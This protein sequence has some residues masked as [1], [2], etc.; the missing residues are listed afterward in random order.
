MLSS[1]IIQ[2]L[3]LLGISTVYFPVIPGLAET[4][5]ILLL[6]IGVFLLTA[7]R[8]RINCYFWLLLVFSIITLLS[9]AYSNFEREL[10]QELLKFL[11]FI[12][13]VFII[14]D[15]FGFGNIFFYVVFAVIHVFVAIIILFVGNDWLIF[16]FPRY[17]SLEGGRGFSFFSSEPSY[18]ATYIFMVALSYT[19]GLNKGLFNSRIL[20]LVL[21]GLLLSTFS[22]LGFILFFTLILVEISFSR[23]KLKIFMVFIGFTLGFLFVLKV[24][25][26]ATELLPLVL[27]VYDG[28]EILDLVLN[29][30]SASTRVLLNALAVLDGLERVIFF[31]K[32]SFHNALPRMLSNYGMSEV[33]N[34]HE[35][36]SALY[37]SGVNLKPQA[38]YPYLFY[39]FGLS[40]LLFLIYPLYVIYK[41]FVC[42]RFLLFIACC[43]WFLLFFFYQSQYINPIQLL[44]FVAVHKFFLKRS[45]DEIYILQSK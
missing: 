7:G 31:P 17:T 1:K 18:A 3:I 2:N 42:K 38:L 39:V 6:L 36:I 40:S 20:Q 28:K 8:V 29:Y 37:N 33:L 10:T 30:P 15:N 35:V 23:L 44:V 25:R 22:L 43:V 24:D 9:L 4:Q 16:L 12:F 5:P 32:E 13:M 34:T 14:Y 11:F 41:A 45:V 21:F 27:A 19:L 26:F